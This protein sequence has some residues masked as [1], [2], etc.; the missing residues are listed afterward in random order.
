Y[1]VR[2]FSFPTATDSSISFSG[3]ANFVYRLTLTVGP[4]AAAPWPTAVARGAKAEVG[5]IGWNLPA[6]LK[7][8]V[9]PALES[10]FSPER[11]TVEAAGLPLPVWTSVESGPVV[12]ETDDATLEKPLPV[13][14]PATIAGR[15][16]AP[17]DVDVYRLSLKSGSTLVAT[18]ETG[19]TGSPVDSHLKLTTPDGALLVENDDDDRND[20]HAELRYA[21]PTDG[22]FLLQIRDRYKFGGPR[23]VYRV[24]LRVPEPTFKLTTGVN[25][26]TQTAGKPLEVVVKIERK[27]G[28]AADVEVALEGMPEGATP[29]LTIPAKDAEGKL[30]FP[31]DAKPFNGPVRLFGTGVDATK[32]V[33][34]APTSNDAIGFPLHHYWLTLPGPPT[35]PP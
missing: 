28:F 8:A 13:P 33:I 12:V 20:R 11:I 3:G 24:R 9:D 25:Q 18:A 7:G 10:V 14:F 35:A 27:D 1:T 32:R 30:I 34:Y 19:F 6:D 29:K 16:T 21:A 17:S 26:F 4:F 22:D 31:A 5:F 15:L 23:F 2:L